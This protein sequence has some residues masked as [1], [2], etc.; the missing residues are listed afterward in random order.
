MVVELRECCDAVAEDLRASCELERKERREC[1]RTL[2]EHRVRIDRANGRA[3]VENEDRPARGMVEATLDPALEAQPMYRAPVET[4]G[5]GGE[6]VVEQPVRGVRSNEVGSW[7]ATEPGHLQ[8][9]AG[10]PDG[11]S[12]E[13][14]NRGRPHGRNLGGGGEPKR[15]FLRR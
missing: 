6:A 4:H 12:D 3:V 8:A 9:V 14:S 11:D 2:R 5:A 1:A 7:G 15:R 10:R 13:S